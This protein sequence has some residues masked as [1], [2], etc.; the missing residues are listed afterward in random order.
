MVVATGLAAGVLALVGP[1]WTALVRQVH[2]K[3]V[4]RLCDAGGLLLI[5]TGVFLASAW[6]LRLPELTLLLPRW[7]QRERS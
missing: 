2:G 4:P 6:L 1:R 7:L 3:L 5:G